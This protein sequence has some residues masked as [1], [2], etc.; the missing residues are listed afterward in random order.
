MSEGREPFSFNNNYIFYEL[1]ILT[2][3]ISRSRTC[4]T[5]FNYVDFFIIIIFFLQMSH[6]KHFPQLGV[7][8]FYER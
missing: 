4:S 5:V 6:F 8:L 7:E 3:F 1:R 2:I